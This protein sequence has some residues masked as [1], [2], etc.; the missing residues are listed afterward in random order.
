MPTASVSNT[1]GPG[2]LL[3]APGVPWEAPRFLYGNDVYSALSSPV[4]RG[5]WGDWKLQYSG[6]S[7]QSFNVTFGSGLEWPDGQ[8]GGNLALLNGSFAISRNALTDGTGYAIEIGRCL[9]TLSE[10]GL[11]KVRARAHTSVHTTASRMNVH[12]VGQSWRKDSQKQNR[13]SF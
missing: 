3:L 5:G 10:E 12:N 6:S 13:D 11:R 4:P 9:K 1:N 2:I 7:V 8:S